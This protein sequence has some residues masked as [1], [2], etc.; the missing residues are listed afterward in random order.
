MGQVEQLLAV[1]PIDG[2]YFEQTRELAPIF[3]EYGLISRRLLVEGAWL[4][5][6][7]S[8]VLPDIQAL[9]AEELGYLDRVINDFKPDDAVTVKEIEKGIKHDVKAVELYLRQRLSSNLNF[10]DYLEL[11]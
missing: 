3:S 7:G 10:D 5:T 11:I 6:L 9:G 2:R 8:G 4:S 1:S